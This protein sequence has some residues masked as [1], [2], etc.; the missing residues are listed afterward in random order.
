LAN[1]VWVAKSGGDF[2]S[3][4]AAM[5]SITDA[6]LTNPYVIKIAPGVYTESTA[7]GLKSFVD[8][9]G[10]GERVT[11]ITCACSANTLGAP[12]GSTLYPLDSGANTELRHLTVA[13]TGGSGSN[14]GAIRI[15]GTLRLTHVT[16]TASGSRDNT[17]IY[18]ASES[19]VLTNVT[20]SAID[21]D[22]ELNH[23]VYTTGDSTPLLTEVTA[24]ARGGPLSLGAYGVYNSGA[25]PTI[26]NSTI[27]GFPFSV[28]NVSASAKVADTTLDGLVGSFGAG[29]FSCIGA[30]TTDFV[31]LTTT[32]EL[33]PP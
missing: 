33:P 11:T 19:P 20:A 5:A 32:C 15:G 4:S 22:G 14:S 8:V 7:V 17:A 27:T 21:V 13:S 30:R 28:F 18:V 25:A 9:E 2:T 23:A 1:V 24:T 3:L 6:S 10:S 26:V 16:A 29:A 12:A 31:E